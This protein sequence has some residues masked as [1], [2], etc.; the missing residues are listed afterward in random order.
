MAK[1]GKAKSKK[2][3]DGASILR[4]TTER[5]SARIAAANATAPAANTAAAPAAA[6]AAAAAAAAPTAAAAA[7]TAADTDARKDDCDDINID[8][9]GAADDELPSIIPR[10][11]FKGYMSRIYVLEWIMKIESTTPLVI[12]KPPAEARQEARDYIERM[13]EVLHNISVENFEEWQRD[14]I[15][16]LQAQAMRRHNLLDELR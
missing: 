7:P 16:G 9:S 15:D 4:S 1:K 13:R 14:A 3:D 10:G 2:E 5:R 6:P 12:D 8:D 11:R